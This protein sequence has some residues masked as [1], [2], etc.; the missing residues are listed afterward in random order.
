MNVVSKRSNIWNKVNPIINLIYI[1]SKIMTTNYAKRKIE[2]LRFKTGWFYMA[3]RY[4]LLKRLG[5]NFIGTGYRIIQPNVCIYHA[6]KLTIGERVTINDNSYLECSGEIEIGSDVMI[7]H[8]VSI[9]S[10][11]HSF[12]NINIPMNE[13]GETFGKISIGNNVWIGA[14]CTIL[15]GVTIGEGAIIGAHSLVNKDVKP[16]EIVGGTPIHHIRFRGDKL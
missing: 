4:V 10:N 14:K 6:D 11:S 2:K 9:L 1:F 15:K 7:G 12:E 16:F 8:G 5:T 13:Q 3:L